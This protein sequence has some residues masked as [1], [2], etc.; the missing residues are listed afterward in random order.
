M[1]GILFARPSLLHVTTTDPDMAVHLDLRQQIM[2]ALQEATLHPDL[3]SAAPEPRGV[4][5]WEAMVWSASLLVSTGIRGGIPVGFLL[6]HKQ[7]FI[8]FL[9]TFFS[10]SVYSRRDILT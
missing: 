3:A 1:A 10:V 6:S 8:C 5:N 4:V 2:A 7:T 9:H